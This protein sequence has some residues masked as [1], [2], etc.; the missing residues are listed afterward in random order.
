ML[1]KHLGFSGSILGSKSVYRFNRPNNFVMFNA[2]IYCDS[3][4]VWRGDIDFALSAST[5]IKVSKKTPDLRICYESGFLKK[6]MP[7]AIVFTKGSV[8][9]DDALKNTAIFEKGKIINS[10]E[11][12]RLI[13][14]QV[15]FTESKG[16]DD[17]EEKQFHKTFIKL[18]NLTLFKGNHKTNISPWEEFQFW[19]IKEVGRTKAGL[20]YPRLW[21]SNTDYNTIELLCYKFFR[22]KRNIH[23]LRKAQMFHDASFQWAC[24]CLSKDL[25]WVKQGIGYIRKKENE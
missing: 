14:K 23:P 9:I 22:R 1:E 12:A 21:L 8:I 15:D 17:F 18:P 6:T 20:I 25:E 7:P 11:T 19:F 5:L 4:L 2:E 16:I 3:T 13:K 24:G 10:K